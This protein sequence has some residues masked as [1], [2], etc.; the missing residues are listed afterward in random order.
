MCRRKM[1]QMTTVTIPAKLLLLE[2]MTAITRQYNL[3][4]LRDNSKIESRIP[5]DQEDSRKIQADKMQAINMKE[6]QFRRLRTI[7]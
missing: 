1:H 2:I 7:Q 3:C 4:Q 6:L 5:L